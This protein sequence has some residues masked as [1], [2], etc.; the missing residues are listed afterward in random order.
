M[1][2]TVNVADY[3]ALAKKRLPKIVFDYLDGGAEDE[4]G[5]ERNR[6]GF[7]QILF[8]PRRLVDVSQRSMSIDLLGKRIPAPMVIAP[9]GLNGIFWPDGD[10][11]LAKA[12]AR[13]G[14]PF[15]LSTAST[16]SIEEVA[17]AS[18]GQFWFQLYVV[19][20]R[21]AD[22]LVSRAQNAGCTTLILTTDVGV[23]GKR[24]RDLRNGFGLPMKY[25][26]KA[27]MDGMLHPRWSWNLLTSGM[28]QLANFASQQSQDAEIQAAL[29]KRQMDASFSWADLAR[30]RDMWP[31]KLL[32]KG[33]IREDDLA[34]CAALGVDGVILSNHGGRQLDSA[35][36]PI[37]VLAN[38]ACV[39]SLP[40]FVD[41]GIRRGADIV[42]AMALGAGAAFLGRATLYGLAARGQ[43]GVLEVL[44]LLKSEIDTTLAQIGCADI[45]DL[46]RDYLLVQ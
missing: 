29:L 8:R 22:L 25:T 1:A 32:V 43:E 10:I 39:T 18:D 33:L 28:P 42:K 14:I 13:F 15:V 6:Q 3:R 31:H 41:S 21:L 23:N 46:S 16:S 4:L 34:R 17:R 37:Q 30:L 7:E 12:A 5:L 19:H 36:S 26:M 27:V 9:T 2:K 11:E 35:V 20:R 38:A 44:N 40:S 24:E 45:N